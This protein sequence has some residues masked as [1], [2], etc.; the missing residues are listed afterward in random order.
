MCP[1]A[2][3]MFFLFT[4]PL[5]LSALLY[6]S[7]SLSISLYAPPSLHGTL[8]EGFDLDALSK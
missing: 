8:Q 5:H 1:V 4:S 7:L 6:L 2:S 3:N